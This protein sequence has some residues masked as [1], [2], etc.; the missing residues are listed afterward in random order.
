MD[1]P[2]S[3]DEMQKMMEQTIE[4]LESKMQS[5]REDYKAK[6]KELEKIILSKDKII[7]EFSKKG[8]GEALQKDLEKKIMEY[9]IAMQNFS[10]P[11]MQIEQKIGELSINLKSM[12]EKYD[13][14]VGKNNILRNEYPIVHKKIVGDLN[15]KIEK[16]KAEK[17]EI[18]KLKEEE[19]KNLEQ[20]LNSKIKE[21]EEMNK[22][23]EEKI[24][25]LNKENTLFYGK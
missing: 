19:Y 22:K 15:S 3:T 7:E 1:N 5:E 14:E 23:N 25:K 18:I 4:S 11:K 24:E 9:T 17:D 20:K 2:L 13:S 12:K 16:L 6:I 10:S 21:L 8:P